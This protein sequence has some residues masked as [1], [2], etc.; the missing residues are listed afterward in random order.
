MRK[1]FPVMKYVNVPNSITTLG[2]AFAVGACYF[3]VE[4]SLRNTLICLALAMIMDV[5]DGFFAYKLDRQ[6]NFGQ[7]LDSLVDSFVCCVMPVLMVF[8]FVSTDTAVVVAAGFYC[9]CGLW[10]LSHYNVVAQSAEKSNFFTGLP[11]P[12]ASLISAMA[13][14]LVVYCNFPAWTLV[15][16]MILLG[17][18]M[19]SFAKLKKYG[20]LQKVSWLIGLIFL[21]VVVL[22]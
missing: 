17:F 1:Y 5:F 4:G 20:F 7:S 19:V 18:M 11:V 10:R 15:L 6:T 16:V 12:G 21:I 8:T 14:W 22:S 13:I 2:I 3:M 9:I